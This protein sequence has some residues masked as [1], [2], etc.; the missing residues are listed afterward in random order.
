[1]VAVALILPVNLDPRL[2]Q[3]VRD[4]KQLRALTREQLLGSIQQQALAIGVG[5]A[6]AHEIDRLN[7]RRATALAMQRALRQVGAVDHILIDGLPMPELGPHTAVIKGDQTCLSISAASIVAKVTRDRWLGCLARR[8]PGY[9]WETN[10]GYGTAQHRRAL[11]ELGLTP[12]HR[13]SFC[14]LELW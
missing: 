8:Y 7:I 10:V 2:L 13:R 3:G 1:V 5:S 12:Q 11:L 4:S 6:A 14:H 9:G